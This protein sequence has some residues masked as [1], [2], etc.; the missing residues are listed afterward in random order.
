[1]TSGQ[2]RNFQ[3]LLVF[4]AGLGT[5]ETTGTLCQSTIRARQ[6][7]FPVSTFRRLR[8][9]P[10]LRFLYIEAKSQ[11]LISQLKKLTTPLSGLQICPSFLIMR[12]L[13]V[14]VRLC[15]ILIVLPITGKKSVHG[16]KQA[17][18]LS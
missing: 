13:P 14:C 17:M 6:G 9:L 8:P 11:Y 1:M 3:G 2:G 4:Q 15:Q 5:A 18:G 16:K 12:K 10:Q 7:K